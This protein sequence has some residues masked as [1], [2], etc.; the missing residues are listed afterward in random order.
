MKLPDVL[1][2]QTASDAI[3]W[4]VKSQLRDDGN[5]PGS[6]FAA[7]KTLQFGTLN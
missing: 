5:R 7:A 4:S 3:E 1:G 6:G 2:A